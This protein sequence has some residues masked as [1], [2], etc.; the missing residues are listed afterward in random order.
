M[1]EYQ[2]ELPPTFLL[3]P[4][5]LSLRQVA[6]P[7]ISLGLFSPTFALFQATDVCISSLSSFFQYSH[8]IQ[9]HPYFIG[10]RKKKE[11]FEKIIETQGNSISCTKSCG[12]VGKALSP[13]TRHCCH[14]SISHT[15]HTILTRDE[16]SHCC[17]T[18]SAHQVTASHFLFGALHSS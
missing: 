18:P 5:Q 4:F 1:Q 6:L 17:S 3:P 12:L 11:I 8:S 14:T 7:H 10:R 16:S 2:G 9:Y 13:Q 15:P